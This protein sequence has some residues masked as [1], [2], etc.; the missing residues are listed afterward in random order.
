M[1]GRKVGQ[2]SAVLNAGFSFTSKG[3]IT[4]SLKYDAVLQD[5]FTAQGVMGQIQLAF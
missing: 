1:S 4:T 3:G 5:G 2:D